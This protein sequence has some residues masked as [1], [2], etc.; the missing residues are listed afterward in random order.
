MYSPARSLLTAV[1][2]GAVGSIAVASPAA[3]CSV[4]GWSVRDAARK[5]AF[6]AEATVTRWNRTA[7]G[8]RCTE[9]SRVA[10]VEPPPSSE[11]PPTR[12]RTQ[13]VVAGSTSRSAT[14]SSSP[15]PIQLPRLESNLPS[16]GSSP[17]GPSS[18]R[19]WPPAVLGRSSA[20]SRPY[21]SQSPIRPP[22]T[23]PKRRP[24]RRPRA[25]S[26]SWWLQPQVGFSLPIA[27]TVAGAEDRLTPE[28]V[29]YS[30]ADAPVRVAPGMHPRSH[31]CPDESGTA[32]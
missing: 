21:V 27:A 23:T 11:R 3:A 24:I 8:C 32:A 2:L 5:A 15:W 16:G 14:M 25:S 18:E 20:W 30:A 7:S 17:M 4:E 26:L 29:L 13:A 19:V 28:A 6:I 31:G 1:I 12:S 22:S 9:S 10:R